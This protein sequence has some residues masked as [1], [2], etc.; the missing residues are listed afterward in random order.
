[1]YFVV[2]EIIYTFNRAFTINYIIF[3]PI[4]NP[5]NTFENTCNAN[6]YNKTRPKF[7]CSS[8]TC[9]TQDNTKYIT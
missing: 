9:N 1:M 3:N 6:T 8:P 2:H 4:S 7:Y 5:F